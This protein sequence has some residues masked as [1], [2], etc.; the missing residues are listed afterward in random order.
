MKRFNNNT[1]IALLLSL[2]PFLLPT[3]V[4]AITGGDPRPLTDLDGMI[5][6][7]SRF[8]LPAAGVI[9]VVMLVYGGFR[10]MMSS[11]DP[12]KTQQAQGLI[13]WTVIGIIVIYSFA[14]VI[15]FMFGR[16]G[17]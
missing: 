8:I 6:K 3:N 17:I 16:L 1:I 15:R 4:Y 5:T 7:A 12:Q 13:T 10:Y 2:T 9:G 11:G 14:L